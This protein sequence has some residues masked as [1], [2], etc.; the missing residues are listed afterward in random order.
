MGAEFID[1]DLDMPDLEGFIRELDM[2][3]ENVNQA[4]R[5]GL[6]NSADIILAEQKRLAPYDLARYISSSEIFATDK[7]KL[8]VSTGYLEDAFSGDAVKD[9]GKEFKPGLV[10]LVFEFGRPGNSSATR[11]D[12]YRYYHR[13]SKKRAKKEGGSGLEIFEGK[14][15]AIQPR[16]H[17]RPGF[18]S[19]K[20]AAA[21]SLINTYNAELDKL[22]RG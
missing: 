19:T 16:P 18:D 4:L 1:F 2:F 21:Q 14:K 3:D 13:Y 15:G 9:N 7:G 6:H 12:K 8:G 20:E 11:K 5:A 10:G 22:E 17:I